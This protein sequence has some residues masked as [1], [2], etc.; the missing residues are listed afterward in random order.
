MTPAQ[1]NAVRELAAPVNA[2]I[3]AR[4]HAECWRAKMSAWDAAYLQAH[5]CIVAPDMHPN[6]PNE[7][8]TDPK[9]TYLMADSDAAMFYEERQAY[10]DSLDLDLPHG[11]CPACVAE[12]LQRDTAHLLIAAASE[13]I[14]EL[15][16]VT[17]DR[18]LCAGMETYREF[19][20]LVCKLVVNAPGYRKPALME[21]A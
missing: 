11:H 8:I 6:T 18:L 19:I 21:V 15:A 20:D 3:M 2:Y 10:V 5:E 7:R 13:A 12:V 14:P 16:G 17:V 1:K 9:L 4:A